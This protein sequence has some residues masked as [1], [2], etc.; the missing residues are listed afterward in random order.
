[1]PSHVHRHHAPA[2]H[3][4]AHAP[5]P[6]PAAPAAPAAAPA[7][8]ASRAHASHPPASAARPSHPRTFRQIDRNHSGQISARE[9]QRAG[10]ANSGYVRADRNRD[11]LITR[12]EF[13]HD[14]AAHGTPRPSTRPL[15]S[16]HAGVYSVAAGQTA[17]F[18]TH[19]RGLVLGHVSGAHSLGNATNKGEKFVVQTTD[20]AWGYGHVQGHPER[21]GWVLMS[22]LDRDHKQSKADAKAHPAGEP[23]YMQKSHH[24]SYVRG[25]D[26]AASIKARKEAEARGVPKDQLPPIRTY[27]TKVKTRDPSKPL[28]LYANYPP[29]PENLLRD[30]SGNPMTLPPKSKVNFRYTPDGKNAVVFVG[31]DQK[32]GIWAIVPMDQLVI[33]PGTPGATLHGRPIT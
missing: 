18:R 32:S 13:V 23:E 22:R 6:A 9:L 11:G 29:A 31:R 20:G 14:R 12:D 3:A 5:A 26:K 15:Q 2:H 21:K 4:P 19:P 17:T 33:P 28:N 25:K 7:A 10:K 24:L 8:H 27:T 16:S 1:M 30:K